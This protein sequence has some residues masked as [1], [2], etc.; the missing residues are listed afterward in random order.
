MKEKYEKIKEKKINTDLGDLCLGF[1]GEIA[2]FIK[3]T[4]E[5]NFE[6][7]PDY[8]YLRQ[9]IKTMADNEKII[10]DYEWDWKIKK[11]AEKAKEENKTEKKE[12]REE[13]LSIT[14]QKI[15]DKLNLL[16]K[17]K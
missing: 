5:I 17:K 14:R 13:L 3:Y 2:K 8:N 16:K 6:D 11:S 12:N 10:F 7:K 9:L 4:R 15:L 1:P